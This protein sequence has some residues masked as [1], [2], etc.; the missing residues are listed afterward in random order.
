VSESKIMFDP[1]KHECTR[2]LW[3]LMIY[4]P[5]D[6]LAAPS[7]IAAERAADHLM[8]YWAQKGH[9]DPPIGFQVVE[10]PHSDEAHAK[11]VGQFYE[12]TGTSPSTSKGV[13]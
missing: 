2:S 1:N 4:G 5:D 12:L 9:E 3:G 6:L 13:E 10:W 7:K 11:D 8:A